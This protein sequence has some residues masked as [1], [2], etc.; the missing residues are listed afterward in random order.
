MVCTYC[1]DFLELYLQEM[2]EQPFLTRKIK[3]FSTLSK[4][5]IKLELSQTNQNNKIYNSKN[6]NRINFIHTKLK[7]HTKNC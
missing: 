4:N 3:L 7:F 2:T 5:H 1:N 6:C